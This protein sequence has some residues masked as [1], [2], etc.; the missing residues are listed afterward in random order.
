MN[1]VPGNA[2]FNKLE[3]AAQA[4]VDALPKCQ[5]CFTAPATR[6]GDDGDACDDYRLCDTC[7]PDQMFWTEDCTWHEPLRKLMKLLKN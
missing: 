3:A 1:E 7:N 5:E 2:W 6:I 4:L